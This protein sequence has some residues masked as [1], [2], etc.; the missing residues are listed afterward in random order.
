[1]AVLV[2][3]AVI[4]ELLHLTLVDMVQVLLGKVIMVAPVLTAAEEQVAAAAA[5]VQ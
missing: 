4:Q 5:Q 1:M 3:V 2:G